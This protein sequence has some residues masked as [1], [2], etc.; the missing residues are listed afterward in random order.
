MLQKNDIYNTTEIIIKLTTCAQDGSL[1]CSCLV[2]LILY[3][4]IT[5]SLL[6]DTEIVTSLSL[7]FGGN[8][9]YAFGHK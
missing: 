1:H 4:N 7:R 2:V 8:V 9:A 5:V 6:N 3:W